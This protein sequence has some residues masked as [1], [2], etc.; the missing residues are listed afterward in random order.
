LYKKP[1]IVILVLVAAASLCLADPRFGSLKLTSVPDSAQVFLDGTMRGT[2]P[3]E[4][5]AIEPGTHLL[6][7][8]KVGHHRYVRE[9][10]F[11]GGKRIVG[12]AVLPVKTTAEQEHDRQLDSIR[13]DGIKRLT[14]TLPRITNAPA[15]TAL[16]RLREIVPLATANRPTAFPAESKVVLSLLVGDNGAVLYTGILKRSGSLVLDDAAVETAGHALFFPALGPD[17]QPVTGWMLGIYSTRA[18]RDSLALWPISELAAMTKDDVRDMV[19]GRDTIM[20]AEQDGTPSNSQTIRLYE[21]PRVVKKIDP[22]YP[23]DVKAFGIE[24]TVSVFMLI[25]VDGQVIRVKVRHSSYN[26]DLDR[27]AVEAV[28]Q[29]RFTPAMTHGGKSVPVWLT[30]SFVFK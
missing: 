27:A 4:V 7:A 15:P 6:V 9:L 14:A 29:W 2:T 26:S 21:T 1:S 22:I 28:K 20:V 25:D 12:K 17:G 23:A 3:L 24:G 11:E 5:Q 10:T 19:A 18:G 8:T 30:R 16:P 13:T